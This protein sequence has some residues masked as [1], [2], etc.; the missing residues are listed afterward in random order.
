[1]PWIIRALREL[2]DIFHGGHKVGI[3]LRRNH[4]T[5]M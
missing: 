2:Q 5:L 3:V 1:V 4:P